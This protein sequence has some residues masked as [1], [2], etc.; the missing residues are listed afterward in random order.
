MI[1]DSD[2][3]Q[4]IS[5]GNTVVMDRQWMKHGLESSSN[6]FFFFF[7][8]LSELTWRLSRKIYRHHLGQDW[9]LSKAA[10][11]KDWWKM[12]TYSS[13]FDWLML[14]FNFWFALSFWSS[15]LFHLQVY[16]SIFAVLAHGTSHF[17]DIFLPLEIY[18]VAA[19]WQRLVLGSTWTANS[20]DFLWKF[21]MIHLGLF[22]CVI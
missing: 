21:S 15:I 4:C 2:V 19:V 16:S 5:F 13:F 14:S 9:F 3:W 22:P 1:C 18:C 12:C 11:G 20:S 17:A 10:L 6:F 7:I 8:E